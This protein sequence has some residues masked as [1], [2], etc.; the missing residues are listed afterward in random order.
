MKKLSLRWKISGLLLIS[1]VVIGVFLI[2]FMSGQV[3]QNLGSEIIAKGK[4]IAQDLAQFSVEA[5]SEEDKIALK[6]LLSNSISYESVEYVLIQKADL[7]VLADTYNGQVP[8]KLLTQQPPNV[9]NITEPKIL[10]LPDD[11]EVIDI[12]TPVEEGYLGFV[13][14]GIR[15]DYVQNKIKSTAIK[16][17]GT[18]I[19]AI[20]L[21]WLIIVY[22]ISQKVIK[23][24]MYLTNRADEISRGELDQPIHI[25]TGDE[26]EELGNALERLRESVKIALDRLKKHRTMRM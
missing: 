18:I 15:Q 6:Q 24:L 14:V 21:I 4:I 13:R 8:E 10:S 5:I 16:V 23:P 9:E 20:L 2:I 26:I 11:V 12:W 1:N 25:S 3:R 7:S 17:V 22:L 19:I